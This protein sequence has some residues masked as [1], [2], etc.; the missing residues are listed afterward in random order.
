LRLAWIHIR[1]YGVGTAVEN[2]CQQLKDYVKTVG[3]EDKYY[4]YI[5][6]KNY[7][8]GVYRTRNHTV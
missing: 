8:K 6:I 5:Q 1:K 3:A 4:E 2:I 7:Q